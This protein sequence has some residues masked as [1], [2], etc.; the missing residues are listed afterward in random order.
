MDRI[1]VNVQTGEVSVVPLTA[2][3]IAAAQEA[4]ANLPPPVYGVYK[5]TIISRMSD[6]ELAAF[7]AGMDAAP[8]RQQMMWNDC[9]SVQSDSPL[10]PVLQAAFAGA[11]GEARAAE[12]LAP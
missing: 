9:Q 11:F 3:E 12:I 4:A 7:K 6:D 2:E 8:L 1:E 5:T 10:F